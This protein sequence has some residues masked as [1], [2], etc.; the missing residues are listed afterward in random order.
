MQS[1]AHAHKKPPACKL[2]KAM[3]VCLIWQRAEQRQ[4][5]KDLWRENR[6]QEVQVGARCPWQLPGTSLRKGFVSFMVQSPEMLGLFRRTRDDLSVQQVV[7]G[8]SRA[9]L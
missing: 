3:P 8:K 5:L 7:C 4:V 6:A 1:G 2:R 9:T